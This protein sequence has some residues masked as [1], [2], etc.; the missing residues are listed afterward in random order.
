M[1]SSG[2][3]N[4][5]APGVPFDRRIPPGCA[6]PPTD[7]SGGH[8]PFLSFLLPRLLFPHQLLES[9]FYLFIYLSIYLF[10]YLFSV[11]REITAVLNFFIYYPLTHFPVGFTIAF[12][13]REMLGS[14]IQF[15][16]FNIHV[17]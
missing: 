5:Q 11:H 15:A 2:G 13:R 3:D 12:I 16:W 9:P 17:K 8:L 6:P 14:L 4:Q 1:P 7:G 10:T